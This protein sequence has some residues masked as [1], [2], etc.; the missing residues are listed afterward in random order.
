MFFVCVAGQIGELCELSY[1]W[2]SQASGLSMA[3]WRM[4]LKFHLEV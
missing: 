1:P 4:Y 2:I 3:F